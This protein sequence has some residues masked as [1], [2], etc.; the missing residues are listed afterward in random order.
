[1]K[2][3]V[4][5]ANGC[6]MCY[7]TD[8]FDDPTTRLCTNNPARWEVAWP[9]QLAQIL[10]YTAV[11][12][13]GYPGSSND[14]IL[15]TTIDWVLNDAPQLLKDGVEVLVV[16]GWSS[17][18]RREFYIDE[19]WRQLIPYHDYSDTAGALLNRVYREVAWSDKESA[20]RFA[21][22]V[23]SLK[24]V[25]ENANIPYFFF[26]ALE[27]LNEINKNSNNELSNYIPVLKTQKFFGSGFD[28][29]EEITQTGKTTGKNGGHPDQ[30]GHAEWARL[31][32]EYLIENGIHHTPVDPSSIVYEGTASVRILDRKVG[33]EKR[34][35]K[36]DILPSTLSSIPEEEPKRKRTLF[37]RIRSARKRDPFIYE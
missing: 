22:Q 34:P 25:L 33:L 4:L 35:Q 32:A 13:A 21:T 26:N 2:G 15:R 20:I 12:N 18:M 3:R 8:L 11:N 31:L 19:N 14:R 23:I 27:S 36:S 29:Y 5:F 10:G 1:M 9:G 37:D 28:G 16:I 6:S 24:S 17:P 30:Q 7:G